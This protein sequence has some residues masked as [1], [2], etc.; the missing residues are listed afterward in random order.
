MY[1]I[2]AHSTQ[3]VRVVE[4]LFGFAGVGF[5]QTD[6]DFAPMGNF[7]S[8]RRMINSNLGG[9]H[10]S[11]AT[12]LTQAS[13][14]SRV[15]RRVKDHHTL[16]HYSLL[17]KNTCVRQVALGKWF[18]L[19][20]NPCALTIFQRRHTNRFMSNSRCKSGRLWGCDTS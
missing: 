7:P 10:L 4:H 5:T 3:F 6:Q 16:L 18:P 20:T 17:L 19:S 14:V 12:C 11:H 2:V 13:L 1:G 9:T 15:F 8:P